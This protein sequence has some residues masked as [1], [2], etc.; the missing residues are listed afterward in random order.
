[1]ARPKSFAFLMIDV[2][3]DDYSLYK[4]IVF[5]AKDFSVAPNCVDMADFINLA[6]LELPATSQIEP[7]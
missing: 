4:T 2:A 1:M 6:G 7:T 3:M 5:A